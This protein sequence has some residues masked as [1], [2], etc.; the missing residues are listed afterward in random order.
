MRSLK[1]LGIEASS[2]LAPV[3]LSKLPLDMRL[4]VSRRFSD[5]ELDIEALLVAFEEEQGIIYLILFV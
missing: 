2:I 5:T 1:S 3:L 4:I